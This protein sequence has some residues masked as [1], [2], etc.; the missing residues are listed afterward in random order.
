MTHVAVTTAN[1]GA[2]PVVYGVAVEDLLA[3]TRSVAQRTYGG[4]AA[5]A[6][7]RLDTPPQ[8]S[9]DG[10][11]QAGTQAFRALAATMTER[12][13]VLVCVGC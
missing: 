13:Q 2:R 9:S 12:T 8:S 4:A 7:R 6:T 1:K 10:A 5:R 11:A 3:A